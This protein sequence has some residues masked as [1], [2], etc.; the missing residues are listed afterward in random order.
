MWKRGNE[1]ESV[2]KAE[3]AL[4]LNSKEKNKMNRKKFGKW[5]VL[6]LVLMISLAIAACGG[7]GGGGA[8]SGG[9][10][11][12][13]NSVAY[14]VMNSAPVGSCPNGGITVYAGI[15]TNSNGV[16]DPA[17]YTGSPQYVCN[18]TN[19]IPIA[20]SL[21]TLPT[22]TT[23]CNG[24]GT[25]VCVG[26]DAD[27]NNVP[28]SITSCQA[29][30]NGSRE[31]VIESI[32]ASPAVVWPGQSTTFS[33]SATDGTANTLT[34]SWSGAQGNFS[35]TNTGATT[36]TAPN[37]VGSYMVSIQVSN[38][39]STVTGY[40]SILVSV[41]P[42]EAIVTS[43]SPSDARSGDTITIIGA[44]FGVAQ[45]TST[46]TIG[47]TA[48]TNVVSW[49]ENKVQAIVPSGAT[50]G[51]VVIANG[52]VTSSPGYIEIPWS[53]GNLDITNVTGDQNGSQIIPDGTGGMIIVWQ[54]YRNGDWDIYAQRVSSAG[55]EQWTAGGIVISRAT[56]TQRYPQIASDGS[57]G[58]IITWEDSRSGTDYD[59]YAQ[60]VNAAGTIQWREDGVA[61]STA[62]GNEYMPQI[63]M[64]GSGGAIIAWGDNRSGTGSDIY[65]QRVNSAG[66]IQWTT[67][68]VAIC[69]ASGDQY[70]NRLIMV[71]DGSG[72]AIITWD[73]FRSLNSDIYAQRVNSAGAV[74]WTT[75][76]VAM[77]TAAATKQLP[78][79]VSDGS[80]G[81]IVTWMDYRSGTHNDIY[82]Q[83][84]NGAGA[85]QWATDGVA[86]STASGNKSGPYPVSDGSGGAIIAWRD[87]RSG[88][89][90]DI[91]AQRVNSTGTI[92]WTVDGVA[93][94]T[95]AGDQS[96][97]LGVS[98][99]VGGAIITWADNRSGNSDIY[100]QRVDGT[101]VARWTT[102]GIGISTA[103]DNQ[104]VSRMVP[105]GT[106]GALITWRD[107]RNGTDYDIYAQRVSSNGGW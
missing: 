95:V 15:D 107:Y 87:N 2:F 26:P 85:V 53:D 37:T 75:D 27:G 89:D 11:G 76:G 68:G 32:T 67:N 104:S 84:V 28:D 31:V 36:W 22:N 41:S 21:T 17:E 102:N 46:V 57:G 86:I 18:G 105:D 63:I 60:R 19:G 96:S 40:A 9:T 74:Q 58:A 54:D 81:A 20:V 4:L 23:T 98:D 48:A 3:E 91:Y 64:D 51:T 33:V 92:Q 55:T 83:R 44:G 5:F 80:G 38:G 78:Q 62:A 59:I 90:Y 77:S 1:K 79:A 24:S 69:T 82:A 88:T 16:L 49:S 103:I 13:K 94:C 34:Y 56:G 30:C 39:S 10:T 25:N 35:T 7:G 50:T 99:G 14:S 45:G 101:G 12:E 65:A 93:L 6:G 106:G 72:G 43:V 70:L 42:Q 52:G 8:T 73:D 66:M 71:G 61:I 100:A 29:V 97:V 47:G